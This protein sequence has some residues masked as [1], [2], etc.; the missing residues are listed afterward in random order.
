MS[1]V[2]VRRRRLGLLVAASSIA[3]AWS[4]PLTG[5]SGG[6]E[7]V[8]ARS[9]VV[10]GGDTLWGIAERVAPGSDP[11]G[12]VDAIAE[13]NAVDAGALVPGQTLVIPGA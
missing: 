3:F 5:G 2:R 13:A 8:A 12:V 10:R 11:R 7:P 4:G 1:R 9:Y 6:L